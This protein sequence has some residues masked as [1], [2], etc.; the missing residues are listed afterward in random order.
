MRKKTVYL[1]CR[2][3]KGWHKG[4]SEIYFKDVDGR[5][6]IGVIPE[7]QVHNEMIKV[8][9]VKTEKGRVEIVNSKN[10]ADGEGFWQ[11]SVWV[12]REIVFSNPGKVKDRPRV[13]K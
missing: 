5:N 2:I 3:R 1:K 7:K 4:Y 8:S 9:V 13:K 10:V 11:S 6:I 12:S